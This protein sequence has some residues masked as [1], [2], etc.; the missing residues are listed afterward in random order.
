MEPIEQIKLVGLHEIDLK[1]AAAA[2]S[3]RFILKGTEGLGPPEFDVAISKGFYQG[4]TP[5]DREIEIKVGLNPIY[6][7]G[8]RPADLRK[9]LYGLI[10]PGDSDYITV[11][12]SSLAR[13]STPAKSYTTQGWVR[14]MEPVPM[15]KDPTVQV[16][17]ACLEP[18]FRGTV[19]SYT[20]A[21]LD[22]MSKS[23]FE[24]PNQGTAQTGFRLNVN[25]LQGTTQFKITNNW[26]DRVL[27]FVYA[28][29]PG[30]HLQIDTTE[31]D[32][33]AIVTRN[34]IQ[35]E[36][37]GTMTSGSEW[38][39]LLGGTTYF[40]GFSTSTWEFDHFSHMPLYL[41]I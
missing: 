23:N 40:K 20:T 32:R 29:L 27:A 9:E 16:T 34:G 4:R 38:L 15:A 3:D 24:M 7:N 11:R 1:I 26:G 8:E 39:Q 13:G 10:S 5:R 19:F 30:D 28:F 12:L 35:T 14:R 41:G 37:S 17:I 18:Y 22:A 21:E 25:F 33:K 2:G 36:I 6:E 31:E